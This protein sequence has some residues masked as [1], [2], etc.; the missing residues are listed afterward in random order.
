MNLFENFEDIINDDFISKLKSHTNDNLGDIE[1]AVKGVFYTLV[2]GL[3][4][5]TNSDMSAGMLYNQIKEK[6]NKSSIPEDK[7]ELFSQKGLIEKVA[8][9][10]SKIISQIFP[11][12]KSPLLS[13]IGSYASTS[14]NVTVITSGLTAS[15]LVDLLGKK[16]TKENLDKEGMMYYLK[17]HHEVLLQKAPESLM[18]KMI[19]ALGLQELIN[20]KIIAPKKPEAAVKSSAEET[21]TPAKMVSVAND[22]EDDSSSETFFN[23]KILLGLGVLVLVGGILYYLWAQNGDF[24][25]FSK[26]DAPVESMNEELMFADS[27]ANLAKDSLA[28]ANVADTTKTV[29]LNNSEFTAFKIYVDDN[30]TAEGKE[31]DFKSIQYLDKTFDLT[32]ASMNIIDS[33]A[34][35]MNSNDKVQI[36]ITAFSENGDLKLNN[37]RAFAVKKVLMKKG[38]NTIRIDAGSGG[39]GGNFPVIKVVSK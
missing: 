15:L 19:P 5:R 14:K 30:T 38:V 7:S 13:M 12:Y 31:F 10:G 18:E 11:A 22:Y 29:P 6:Y 25:F 20:T 28:T 21:E 37:K 24:S 3:I 23:K 34:T 4:R 1:V 26:E 35:L 16:I 9:D 2:A 33:L 32:S 39:S 8:E 27:L 36:K 17:Q